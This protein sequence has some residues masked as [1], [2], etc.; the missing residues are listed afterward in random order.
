MNQPIVDSH[1]HF[2]DP[3]QLQYDW[4]ASVPAIDRAFTPSELSAQAANVNLEKIVFVECGC[5]PEQAEDEVAWVSALAEV[6]PRIRGIVANA[7]LEQGVA[8]R[9]HLQRLSAYPL[10]KGVR[11][12]TQSEGPGF[13]I[14]PDFVAGVQMLDD[15]GFSFDIC[16][17]HHQLGDV[18]QLVQQCPEVAFVLDHVGKPGIKAGLM[19]PWREQISE[20]ASFPNVNCKISGLVTEADVDAW[21]PG[22][23]QLYIDHIIDAFGIDRVMYGGDWPVSLL[24]TTYQQWIKVLDVATATLSATNKEK[25]FHLNANRFYRLGG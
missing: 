1:I 9:E 18:L 17:I 6:E 5:R 24:A 15:F 12:V 22:D 11:R 2:W 8:V 14:Q 13:A 23:L 25:L 19:S 3:N 4:L 20:L 7:A 10:V 21:T 16:I